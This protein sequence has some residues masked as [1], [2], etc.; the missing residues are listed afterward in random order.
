ML[1]S[2]L[3]PVSLNSLMEINRLQEGNCFRLERWNQDT[4][5]Y[6][7]EKIDFET[8]NFAVDLAYHKT[9]IS[10]LSFIG[11]SHLP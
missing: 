1:D 4:E 10:A 2:Q 5:T 6:K 3:Q 11:Y 7:Q 8:K 9:V